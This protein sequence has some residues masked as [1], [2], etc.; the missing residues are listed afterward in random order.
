MSDQPLTLTRYLLTREK[1][2]M[3]PEDLALVMERISVIAKSISRKLVHASL[4]GSLGYTGDT[5]VQGEQ[6]KKLDEWTNQTFL[7]VFRYGHP[8]CSIVS[9][10][11]ESPTHYERNCRGRSY[12]VLCDPLDGSSNSDNNGLLATIFS[13]RERAN[14][15]GADVSDLLAPGNRQA[16]AGYALYGPAT[17]LVFTAGAGVTIFTLDRELGEFILWREKVRMPRRGGTYAVNQGNY[18]RWHP[19]M[20]RLIEHM[21]SRKDKTTSYA[22]RYCGC[23]AGDFHRCLLDGGIYMYPGE[24]SA[25][26]KSTNGKLR[27]MYE[28]APMA[29]IAEQAGGRASNGSVDILDIMP[30]EIHERQPVYIGGAEDVTLAERFKPES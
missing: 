17:Q 14:G 4:G 21:T 15:H 16:A 26:G 2:T 5:N 24:V 1:T 7:K 18:S 13:V 9:E 11:M 6:Q 12:A 22:L 28:L 10:E 20:R 27:L 25:D 19:G 29:M 8:V 30:V 23:F 3:Q